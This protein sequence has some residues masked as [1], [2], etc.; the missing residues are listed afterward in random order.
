MTL[1]TRITRTGRAGTS[2]PLP[3][4]FNKRRH[5]TS[6]PSTA[7][8]STAVPAPAAAATLANQAQVAVTQAA[9]VQKSQERVT[10]AKTAAKNAATPAGKNKA[11][12]TLKKATASKR[13]ARKS[14]QVATAQANNAANTTEKATQR[15]AKSLVNY[16]K[17][18]G[19]CPAGKV[20]STSGR[21]VRPSYTYT[22]KGFRIYT[23][24]RTFSGRTIRPPQFR[25][26]GRS[27]TCKDGSYWAEDRGCRVIP[28][29]RPRKAKKA[30]KPKKKKAN[31]PRSNAAPRRS[32]R[33]A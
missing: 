3:R 28:K 7:P 12:K 26:L 2:T 16:S 20:Y 27:G 10:R 4:R 17:K 30:K 13:K 29:S 25:G 22:G 24:V 9:N 32:S 23:K 6:V 11:K 21:C 19:E 33:L 8:V 1:V 31:T 14:V 18:A 15:K 5:Q